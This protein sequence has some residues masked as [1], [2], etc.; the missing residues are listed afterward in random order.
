MFRTARAVALVVSCGGLL[1]A[2]CS[3][4]HKIVQNGM[5][6][7]DALA[8]SIVDVPQTDG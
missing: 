8:Q 4:Q 2:G 3:A 5:I 6:D 7:K 1:L